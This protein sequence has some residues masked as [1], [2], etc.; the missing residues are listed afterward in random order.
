VKIT[1]NARV[2]HFRDRLEQRLARAENLLC[3]LHGTHVQAVTITSCEN[4]WFDSRWVTCC[5]AL[6]GQAATIIG[7]RC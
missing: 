7:N 6:T 4:G 1:I 3:E 5:E 2:P